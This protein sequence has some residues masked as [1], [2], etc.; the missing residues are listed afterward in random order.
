MFTDEKEISTK[1][2]VEGLLD[3]TCLDYESKN[4]VHTGRKLVTCVLFLVFFL[5]FIKG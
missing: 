5:K 2:F 3:I 4:K 1:L